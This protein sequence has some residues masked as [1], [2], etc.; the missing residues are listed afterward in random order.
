MHDLSV[1]LVIEQV[2]QR[3][4]IENITDAAKRCRAFGIR[5]RSTLKSLARL[6]RGSS[7]RKC[8]ASFEC[9]CICR[10]ISH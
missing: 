10:A 8:Q 9:I 3:E 4:T 1:L 2:S 6:G 5:N 7:S